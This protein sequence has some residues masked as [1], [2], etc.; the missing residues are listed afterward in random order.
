M[1]ETG[2]NL[3]PF[4]HEMIDEWRENFKGVQFLHKKT[5][6]LFTGAVDDVWF[7]TDSEEL[8][9]VDYKATAKNGEVSLDADWQISYKRQME[10]YQWLL[11]KNGFKVSNDGYFVYCNGDKSKT[12]FDENTFSINYNTTR[13]HKMDILKADNNKQNMIVMT[14]LI[15]MF[16]QTHFLL[17]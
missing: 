16:L 3:I 7:D 15:R 9:V 11:R 14:I 2:K 13:L 4:Q 17:Y 10:F 1:K 6:L 12:K 8:V 5:N